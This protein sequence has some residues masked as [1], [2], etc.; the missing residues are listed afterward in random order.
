MLKNTSADDD[1]DDLPSPIS[2]VYPSSPPVRRNITQQIRTSSSYARNNP[3]NNKRAGSPDLISPA[4]TKPSPLKSSQLSDSDSEEG[5]DEQLSA[6]DPDDDLSDRDDHHYHEDDVDRDDDDGN[7]RHNEDRRGDS[8][9]LSEE[10]E[11]EEAEDDDDDDDDFSVADHTNLSLPADQ[12]KELAQVESSFRHSTPDPF[13]QPGAGD[14]DADLSI[15]GGIRPGDSLKAS[16]PK[17]RHQSKLSVDRHHGSSTTQRKVSD[18]GPPSVPASAYRKDKKT[19]HKPTTK[20]KLSRTSLAVSS[21]KVRSEAS[22]PMPELPTGDEDESYSSRSVPASDSL[23][24]FSSPSTM[25]KARN[26]SRA[27]SSQYMT[28]KPAKKSGLSNEITSTDTTVRRPRLKTQRSRSSISS[29]G[30]E[31]VSDIEDNGD[32]PSRRNRDSADFDFGFDERRSSKSNRL[33]TDRVVRRN[34]SSGS[35]ASSVN[36][37]AAVEKV[38]EDLDEE[39]RSDSGADSDSAPE[40]PRARVTASDPLPPETQL[41]AQIRNIK[42][43]ETIARDFRKR[44]ASNGSFSPTKKP[45]GGRGMTLKEQSGTIDK[46]QKENW[47][48][49]IKVFHLNNRLDKT[50]EESVKTLQNENGI[51]AVENTQLKSHIKTLKKRIKQL[52][53]AGDTSSTRNGSDDA[54]DK[55]DITTLETEVIYWKEQTEKVEVE[56][57][58]LRSK[59]KEKESQCERLSEIVRGMAGGGEETETL[60]DFLE[61]ETNRRKQAEDDNASLRREVWDLKAA[62]QAPPPN[63]MNHRTRSS[64]SINSDNTLVSQLRLENEDL[65]REVSAQLS[66]LTS[67]NREKER[68]YQEIEELKL[69]LPRENNQLVQVS[70][71]DR[72][73]SR[74]SSNPQNHMTDAEREDYENANGALRDKISEHK[75]KIQDLE[76][77]LE[78][79]LREMD[80]V[81]IQ[82]QE[83]GDLAAEYEDELEVLNADLQVVLAERNEQARLREELE[84]DFDNLKEEAEEEIQRLEEEIDIRVAEMEKLE[85][86]LRNKDENFGALQ[87]EMRTLSTVVVRLE[88]SAQERLT[89]VQ[90]LEAD[91]EK[92]QKM[93]NENEA[94][95]TTLEKQIHDL[96]SKSE[97]LGVQQE[98]AQGEIAF[99]REEQDS[100]KIKIGQ[101]ESAMKSLEEGLK[102]EKERSRSLSDRLLEER[103]LMDETRNMNKAEME[104]LVGDK[105][106]EILNMKEA[107]RQL[108]KS[109]ARRETE[110]KEWKDKL[111]ELEGSIREAIGDVGSK[112]DVLKAVVHLQQEL[113]KRMEEIGRVKTDLA[114]KDRVLKDRENL[115]EN[116]A[117]EMRRLQD[118]LEKERQAR[119]SDRAVADTL[120]TNHDKSRRQIAQH[121]SQLAELE[122]ARSKDSKAL[123]QLEIQ[124][125]EQLAERNSLLVQL[126]IRLSALCGTEWADK[127]K[128]IGKGG[129]VLSADASV[130]GHLPGFSKS[131]L[132]AAK[133]LETVLTGF[134]T[135]IRN[136]E[137]DLWKEY[138]V[139]ENTLETRT[140][141]LERLEAMVRDGV[142]EQSSMR[143][144]ITKLKTENRLL[145][146]E[147]NV[148][149]L[150]P[151]KLPLRSGVA[152]VA[153]RDSLTAADNSVVRASPDPAPDTNTLAINNTIASLDDVTDENERRW[154]LRLRE[155]EKRLKAEREARLLDRTGAK[156]RLEEARNER[157]ALKKELERERT[158]SRIDRHDAEE[159]DKKGGR[160]SMIPKPSKAGGGKS[161]DLG[162][163]NGVGNSSG[164]LAPPDDEDVRSLI[165]RV[166]RERRG[167]HRAKSRDRRDRKGNRDTPEVEERSRN[168]DAGVSRADSRAREREPGTPRERDPRERLKE[169]SISER[170]SSARSSMTKRADTTTSQN[171]MVNIISSIDELNARMERGKSPAKKE[172]TLS[173][174]KF[175][176]FFGGKTKEEA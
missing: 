90:E 107:A 32:A 10:E 91:L 5:D 105:N 31:Q 2:P 153:S 89:R 12:Q 102:D 22:S 66:M 133:N 16:K 108:K 126:W 154:I 87:E 144:E 97:R 40:T 82:R 143:N 28:P 167:E 21:D 136:I 29:V 26:I 95:M 94:E 60:R 171:K 79:K 116:T 65:R 156:Q 134:K 24:S 146:A 152:S 6:I 125:K 148:V 7:G 47:D 176:G 15:V 75:L 142:G 120:Q 168:R 17:P 78:T 138:A 46:L 172:N 69:G 77:E 104:K 163:E 101:L 118:L 42:V 35:V 161:R 135:R 83:F 37:N 149:R 70:D 48:L 52:E 54:D 8:P 175:L 68:L 113:E 158:I 100:D 61:S 18:M 159:D 114:D 20:S 150:Q 76:I 117:L 36:M 13:L 41:N 170:G 1:N 127:N 74:V 38:L 124:Y 85:E 49:R 112:A 128:L 33:S 141:R 132:A 58:T 30:S 165:V 3:N 51:L 25:A 39:G 99:L 59:V 80:K 155:L 119:K 9:V 131:V 109:L 57:E 174:R 14:N 147:L 106:Q 63:D 43:P 122:K 11:E 27:I 123:S 72:A 67:R 86:D 56:V 98:S 151:S 103:K 137:R 92:S 173:P 84:Q 45:G 130:N 50:S 166:E 88:D 110:V 71:Y 64:I 157:E 169:R 162:D 4:M 73:I 96:T 19:D 62:A 164:L 111:A 34:V 145:K 140:R 121:Q 55:A 160:M 23:E 93:I 129:A 44:E 139:V 81:V 115:L 53:K